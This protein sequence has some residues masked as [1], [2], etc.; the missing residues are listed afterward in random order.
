MYIDGELSLAENK[1]RFHSILRGYVEKDENFQFDNEAMQFL[2]S[3][4]CYQKF[5]NQINLYEKIWRDRLDSSLDNFDL[6]FLD[7]VSS[8]TIAYGED[9]ENKSASWSHIGSWLKGWKQKGKTFVVVHHAN[10]KGD[11]IR[12]TSMISVEAMTQIRLNPIPEG[13]NDYDGNLLSSSF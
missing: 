2:L 8:L 9:F 10:K 1:S 4:H 12:G 5:G 7:N 6:I 11:S 13:L 3:E